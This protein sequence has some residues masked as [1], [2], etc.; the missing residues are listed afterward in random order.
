MRRALIRLPLAVVPV[1][2]AVTPP[3]AAHHGWGGYQADAPQSLTGR[4][5]RVQ[6]GGP[7][8]IIWLRTET[9]TWEVVLAPPSRMRNRG[10]P[11]DTLRAGQAVEVRGYP[12]RTQANELRAEW[13]RPE[14]VA[15]PV[16]LR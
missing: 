2:C 12:H 4:I 15:Q 13:I 3:A 5:E 7:H 9:K 14:G 6:A 1:L 16:Q 10:L 8:A 11:P